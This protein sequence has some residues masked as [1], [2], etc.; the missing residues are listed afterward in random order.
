MVLACADTDASLIVLMSPNLE[1][2]HF[3]RRFRSTENTEPSTTS[4]TVPATFVSR[5]IYRTASTRRNIQLQG[6]TN[7]RSLQICHHLDLRE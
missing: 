5:T 7:V 4:P 6:V 3:A 1:V 2:R